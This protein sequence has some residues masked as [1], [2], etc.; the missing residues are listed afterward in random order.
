ML[1]HGHVTRS[2]FADEVADDL[3]TQLDT[4][5]DLGIDYVDLRSAW[6]T[7]VLDFDDDEIETVQRALDERDMGVA[8]IGSPIGKV[9]IEDPFADHRERFHTAIERAHQFDADYIR[10]FSYWMPADGSPADYRQEVIHRM[11]EK[12]DVAEEEDVILLHENEKDIYGD[13]PARCR[14]LLTAVDSPN[15]RAIFDP[16]NFLEVGVRPYPDALLDLVEYVEYLHIKDAQFGERGAIEPAGEGDGEIPAVLRA[17]DRRG[18]EGFAALEPHLAAAEEKG[19]FSGP[20]AFRVADEA[21]RDC[22]DESGMAY[23]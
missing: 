2:G 15:F 8:C 18:F 22:L 7:N 19:G 16:A 10:L 9:P 11:Q 4:F 21:L 6:G 3:E 13:T 20:E 17:L 12:A 14:D 1:T 5:A 23:D